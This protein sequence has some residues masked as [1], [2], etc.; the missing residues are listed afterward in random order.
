[1][2]PQQ[3][4]LDLFAPPRLYSPWLRLPEDLLTSAWK[5]LSQCVTREG[6]HKF[7]IGDRHFSINFRA[8]AWLLYSCGIDNLYCI[9]SCMSAK[10]V[11]SL[12]G[13]VIRSG[14]SAITQIESL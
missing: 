2:I 12:L 14:S 11:K 3:L 5:V 13:I 1:M 8:G 9:G 7:S 10:D 6:P 4:T